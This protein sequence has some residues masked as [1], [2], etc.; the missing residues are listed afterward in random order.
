MNPKRAFGVKKTGIEQ[1]A[2]VSS[3][4]ATS[5]NGF[6]HIPVINS[7]PQSEEKSNSE[8]SNTTAE[9]A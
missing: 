3:P 7:I 1:L 6:A 4:D 8:G 2:D 5:D 9:K